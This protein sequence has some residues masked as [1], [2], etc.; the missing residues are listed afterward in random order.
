VGAKQSGDQ[1][2]DVVLFELKKFIGLVVTRG[3][4]GGRNFRVKI[5]WGKSWGCAM[6]SQ[7]MSSNIKF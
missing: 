7:A 4:I 6:F 3:V 5:L 2:W 1:T